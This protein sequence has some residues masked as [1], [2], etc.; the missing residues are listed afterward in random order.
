[1]AFYFLPP[2]FNVLKERLQKSAI[3]RSCSQ[4]GADAGIESQLLHLAG[5]RI[6]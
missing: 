4:A 2:A 1:M 6:F 5:T 3:E